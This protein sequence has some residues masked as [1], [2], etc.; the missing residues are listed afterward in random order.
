MSY[1]KIEDIQY[2]YEN[3]NSQDQDSLELLEAIE[4]QL[5]ESGYSQKAVD[6]FI[7]TA[8]IH[9]FKS[10]IESSSLDE[11]AKGR[12]IK[13]LGKKGMNFIKT[14]G[15]RL[16]D[17]GGKAGSK[18]KDFVKNNPGKS[19]LAGAGALTVGALATGGGD[20]KEPD[21]EKIKLKD[22]GVFTPKTTDNKKVETSAPPTP[23]KNVPDG[24]ARVV[25]GG[26][27]Q[28]TGN[29]FD[30]DQRS[31]GGY[32]KKG[33]KALGRIAGGTADALTGN[34]TDFDKKGGKP[35]GAS[36]VAAGALDK[37]T[38]DRTDF[39]KRGVT[40]LNKGQRDAQKAR[41]KELLDKQ[42]KELTKPKE[43]TPKETPKETK[44]PTVVPG[45]EKIIKAKW[46]N[47]SG[48]QLP[49][50]RT[51]GFDKGQINPNSSR[52]QM[53]AR[54]KEMFGSKKVENLRD[55]DAAFQKAK[56]KGS[57]YS[58]DDFA[59][60]FPT[61]NTAKERRKRNRVTS[62]MDME[63]Y[64]A[65]DIV[66]SYLKETQQVDSLDEAL[67][68]MMEMDAST[69]QG[70]VKDFEM[71]TEEEADRMKDERLEKYGIGHDGSDRKAGSSGRSD[72]K[73]SKGKTVL[74]KET[75]KKHGKGKSPLDVAK[76]NIIAKYGKGAIAP[77]KK[78]KKS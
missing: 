37:L 17:A 22:P 19:S 75:E 7:E 64:D 2:L 59:K 38:G 42:K 23:K 68:I 6:C 77:S 34:L 12:F 13:N 41:E 16:Q 45:S 50:A 35:F 30:F 21:D 69:I 74:Q 72:S 53:I 55:Q 39:D 28:A 24:L 32:L 40:P 51:I 25:A 58:M 48:K 43:E 9:D 27:D 71:L 54:N 61:S 29:L 70:I 78:K 3:I 1:K 47:P 44:K 11:G 26:L 56:R 20:K 62:V 57:G 31:G 52:G 4:D 63:S 67:Y 73:K 15:K 10:I 49:K 60:D 66:L 5:R 8:D 33:A 76:A 14:Q 65:F 18:I 36:R 46:A